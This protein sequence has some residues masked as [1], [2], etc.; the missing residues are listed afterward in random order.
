[1]SNNTPWVESVAVD[2]ML[3]CLDVA[4]KTKISFDV[5]YLR[6]LLSEVGTTS[7]LLISKREG[8]TDR[9][10][11]SFWKE[12]A[13][14]LSKYQEVNQSVEED[15]ITEYF[16]MFGVKANHY[17]FE[18][19]SDEEKEIWKKLEYDR[20]NNQLTPFPRDSFLTLGRYV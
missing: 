3:A 18:D 15:T 14:R 6:F 12:Y 11:L 8:L 17:R 20:L 9:L 16:L 1:M 4:W 2:A 13:K 10:L 5:D 19:L 7:F